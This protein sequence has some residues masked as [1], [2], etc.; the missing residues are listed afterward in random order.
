MGG[1]GSV[2]E[3]SENNVSF[4]GSLSQQVSKHPTCPN[5]YFKNYEVKIA[6]ASSKS[7]RD[8]IIWALYNILGYFIPSNFASQISL[9]GGGGQEFGTKSQ[10][11]HIPLTTPPRNKAA[12]P[13]QVCALEVSQFE[14]L[15]QS[16]CLP[17]L[18]ATNS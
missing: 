9:G 10:K 6:S 7:I 2:G 12:E 3:L 13:G 17:Q 16:S 18:S 8:W 11:P 4:L 1:L 15:G 14:T 5:M